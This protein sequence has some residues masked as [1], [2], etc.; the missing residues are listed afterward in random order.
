M[1][2]D[3]TIRCLEEKLRRY[4][5]APFDK[6][7]D[8]GPLGE[9]IFNELSEAGLNPQTDEKG[10]I[11]IVKNP[12]SETSIVISSHMDA[13]FGDDSKNYAFGE[14][15]DGNLMGCF[16]NSVGCA[17]NMELALSTNPKVRTYH[18]FTTGEETGGSGAAH[19]ISAIAKESPLCITLDVSSENYGEPFNI[20]N[21]SSTIGIGRLNSLTREHFGRDPTLSPNGMFDE[22]MVYGRLARA[23]SVCPIVS[24][25]M[26]SDSCR[27]ER[28]NLSDSYFFLSGFL[29]SRNLEKEIKS[30]GSSGAFLRKIIEE[31]RVVITGRGHSPS[32]HIY[33]LQ[34]GRKWLTYFFVQHSQETAPVFT[35]DREIIEKVRSPSEGLKTRDELNVSFGEVSVE[36]EVV[37]EN[38]RYKGMKLGYEISL[39]PP[40]RFREVLDRLK[41][42]YSDRA[43]RTISY[44]SGID[45]NFTVKGKD[46]KQEISDTLSSVLTS[47]ESLTGGEENGIT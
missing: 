13:V 28:K 33:Y 20:E 30:V 25:S 17:I 24:G 36:A 41:A 31:A 3:T 8:K 22:S 5:L 23:F 14:T 10:N 38:H 34:G 12:G 37:L 35:P 43:D 6:N 46:H 1:S 16:D 4:S 32:P 18:A 9:I 19:L 2:R 40:G 21:I 26:H 42:G 39:S 29:N 44:Y 15:G 45:L 27:M 7:K 47:Y 11:F